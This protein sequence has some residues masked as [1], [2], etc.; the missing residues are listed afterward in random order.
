MPPDLFC[1]VFVWEYAN[2]WNGS[3]YK[4]PD[5]EILRIRLAVFPMD[6]MNATVP[7]T[8]T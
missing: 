8:S 6:H 1:T 4:R 7:R 2:N 5:D 3:S